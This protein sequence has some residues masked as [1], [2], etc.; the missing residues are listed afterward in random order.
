MIDKLIESFFSFFDFFNN[1]QA[2]KNNPYLSH[3]IL[4]LFNNFAAVD[5]MAKLIDDC[6]TF[7]FQ[8]FF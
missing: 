2:I 5:I 7:L 8:S 6:Y 1:I 4:F 3:I